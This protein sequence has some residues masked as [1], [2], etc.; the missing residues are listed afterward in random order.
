MA[1]IEDDGFHFADVGDHLR[2]HLRL[3]GLGEV[4]ARDEKLAV[5]F[6]NRK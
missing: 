4:Q 6:E 5:F 3:D 2:P 1:G